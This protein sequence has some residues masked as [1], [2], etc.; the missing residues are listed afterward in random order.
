MTFDEIFPHIDSGMSDAAPKWTYRLDSVP[1]DERQEDAPYLSA[2]SPCYSDHSSVASSITG[3]LS[4]IEY[5]Y[6]VDPHVLGSGHH[7]SVRECV[8]RSTGQCYAVKSIRKSDPSVKPAGLAR[9]IQLL[10]EMKHES[11]V[12]LI[13]VYE[14]YEYV[15][16]VTDLCQGGELFDR[17]IERSSEDNGAAC[18]SE[19]EAARI[20]TQI[21]HAVSYMHRHNIVHRDIKPEN[22]LFETC[23]DDS[24]IKVIDFGLARKH[25]GS[26]EPPMSNIVGTP[27]YIAPDVLKKR[28]DKSCD[29]WSVG[30]IAYILLCGYPPF[31]GADN[32]EV[33]KSVRTGRLRF[34]SSDWSSIDGRAKDFIRQLLQR[35]PR[36]R[37][38]A[39][40][41]LEHPWLSG[42]NINDGMVSDEDRQDTSV[43]VVFNELSRRDSI[44]C[45]GDEEHVIELPL[46]PDF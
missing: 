14:D 34:P 17:I 41:A 2:V 33:Y 23:H 24:H 40:E 26:V 16:L 31:N 39:E 35:D 27:Y 22:I 38:T 19:D 46:L 12:R 9:E 36:K 11:I 6:H 18:F 21:L 7:G 4:D 42:Y 3:K 30:V 13:D 5:K 15:H 1:Y 43:E 44:I 29:L 28:Y 37:M 32:K 45:G 8:D 10:R 25:C 20:M